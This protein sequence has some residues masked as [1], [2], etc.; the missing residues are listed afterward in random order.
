[1]APPPRIVITDDQTER[2]VAPLATTPT[3]ASPTRRSSRHSKPKFSID[4]E[5]AGYKPGSGPSPL[6]ADQATAHH[7]YRAIRLHESTRLKAHPD[8]RNQPEYLRIKKRQKESRLEDKLREK[9]AAPNAEAAQGLRAVEQASGIGPGK[10]RKLVPKREYDNSAWQALPNGGCP[11]Q[12]RPAPRTDD[13]PTVAEVVQPRPRRGGRRSDPSSV[14]SVC[15]SSTR[16]RSQAPKPAPIL[17]PSRTPSPP[18]NESASSS[19]SS[20]ESENS[21]GALRTPTMFE[22]RD[23]TSFWVRSN[24]S[25]SRPLVPQPSIIDDQWENL[26]EKL[27]AGLTSPTP[28]L[29]RSKR[30]L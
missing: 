17:L 3:S 26:S 5:L 27:P 1:M 20:S 4:I 8:W 29:K 28:V 22:H 9:L 11:T 25:P 23:L 2:H 24:G 14:E 30:L 10:G 16:P 6:L 15:A 19:G 13:Q 21:F 18:G 7:V 12:T